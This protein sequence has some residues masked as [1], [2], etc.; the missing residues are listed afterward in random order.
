MQG[1]DAGFD[2]DDDELDRELP[3]DLLAVTPTA[4]AEGQGEREPQLVLPQEFL[5]QDDRDLPPADLDLPAGEGHGSSAG[6]DGEDDGWD[7]GLAG[8]LFGAEA[9]EAPPGEGGAPPPVLDL[10]DGLFGP[11]DLR[12]LTRTIS[13]RGVTTSPRPRRSGRRR[14][15]PLWSTTVTPG[16]R[17]GRL[18]R[19][20]TAGPPPWGGFPSPPSPAPCGGGTAS[21]S[22]RRA[23]P[24]RC[25]SASS[26]SLARTRPAPAA[27]RPVLRGGPSPATPGRSRHHHRR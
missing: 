14:L 5:S 23:R 26:W 3:A 19:S 21:G 1:W 9:G 10:P 6:R 8:P 12:R 4:F 15:W 7:P 25:C 13:A 18:R 27:S 2:I 17:S 22:R 16:P 20:P 24:H 11:P